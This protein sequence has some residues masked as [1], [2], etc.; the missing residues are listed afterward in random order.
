VL[1]AA[2]VGV[3]GAGGGGSLPRLP[4]ARREADAIVAAAG[5]DSA[6]RAVD[7]QASRETALSGALEGFRIVHFAT[8]GLLNAK[9]P[10]LSG[11][12]LS[13]VDERGRP[14][15]GFLR[16]RDVYDLRLP[17]DL[18]VLSACQTAL[19][20]DVQG[21]GLVGLTRGFMHAGAA[22]V[23]ASLWPVDDVATAELMRRLYGRML[24]EG[25]RPAAALRDAQM[26]MAAEA[27]WRD[28]YYW[29][30]FVLQGEWR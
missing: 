22:R 9:R 5:V 30:G 7:F 27:P 13:L 20:E 6:F 11:L 29:A 10:E 12:V 2:V 26:E 8:H 23:V 15:D 21:E 4:F 1:D 17:A 18:V 3:R 14:R 24:R 16:V 28:P 19:G 25:T